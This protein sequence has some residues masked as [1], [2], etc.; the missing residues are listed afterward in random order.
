MVPNPW[1]GMVF[2]DGD[3]ERFVVVQVSKR[4]LRIIYL[5]DHFAEMVIGRG[6]WDQGFDQG[7]WLVL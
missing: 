5:E 1:P 6:V 4:L 7:N 2:Q 3:G